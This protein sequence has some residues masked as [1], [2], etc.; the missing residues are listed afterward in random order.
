MIMACLDRQ[1]LI[2]S[3]DVRRILIFD[4]YDGRIDPKKVSNN[5]T[6]KDVIFSLLL[7]IGTMRYPEGAFT[8]KGSLTTTVR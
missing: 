3:Q 2:L 8:S 6:K 4:I 1:E 5:N 7:I